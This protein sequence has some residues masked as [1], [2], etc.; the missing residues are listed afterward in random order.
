MHQSL[1]LVLGGAASGKSVWAEALAERTANQRL[2]V[3]TAQSWDE[4]MRKKIG[5]HQQ[6]R[7]SSW[8]TVEAPFDIA[9]ALSQQAPVTLLDCATMWLSNHMLADHDIARET[10]NLITALGE[11]NRPV[12]IVSNEVG[13]S[14]VPENALARQFQN[15]QGALNQRLAT[16]ANTV[17]FVAAGLPLALKGPLT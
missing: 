4:E 14:G 6:R 8:A 3:A 2:Y 13:L 15:A 11:T 10:E 5:L 9:P 17:V 12:I 7:D 16:I 1:T